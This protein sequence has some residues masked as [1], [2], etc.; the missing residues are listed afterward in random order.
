MLLCSPVRSRLPEGPIGHG[1]LPKAQL[2][3]PW[4]KLTPAGVQPPPR[5]SHLGQPATGP[6]PYI[7]CTG[8]PAGNGR[9]YCIKCHHLNRLDPQPA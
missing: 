4:N 2:T 7:G 5:R 9:P 3:M 1:Q 6:A 8:M